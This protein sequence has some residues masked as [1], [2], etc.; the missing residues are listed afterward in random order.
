[1][2]PFPLFFLHLP[3]LKPFDLG[4]SSCP[5]SFCFLQ[6]LSTPAATE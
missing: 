1:L 4:L 6:L 5:D 2:Q 3:S